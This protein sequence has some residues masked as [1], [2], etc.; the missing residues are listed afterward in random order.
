MRRV[1]ILGVVTLLSALGVAAPATAQPLPERSAGFGA[2]SVVWQQRWMAWAFGSETNPLLRDNFCG[3]EIN[4][5]FF[6][7]A[8]ANPGT[9][10]VACTIPT[11]TRLLATPGAAIAWFPT[12][13]TTD[14]G[15]L[16]ARDAFLVGI[17]NGTVSLDGK[18]LAVPREFTRVGVYKIPLSP[19]SLIKTVD[20]NTA[21]LTKTRVSS[22]GWF[23]RLSPLRRGVHTLVISDT[24]DGTLFRIIFHITVAPRKNC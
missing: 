5:V 20:P 14:Q 13:A 19:N 2:S 3:E 21:N 8:A 16:E 11:G 15:L 22:G 1:F 18:S 24:I 7:N 10:E 6:L 12:D 17:T 4:N 9:V 23:M